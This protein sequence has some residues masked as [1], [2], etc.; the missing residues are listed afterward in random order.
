MT[1]LEV[2][3]P[4]PSTARTTAVQRWLTRLDTRPLLTGAALFALFTGLFAFVQFGTAALADNDGFYHLRLAALM[5]T[6]PS[7]AEA[8]ARP[9]P[10]SRLSGATLGILTILLVALGV[11][12]APLL[13]VIVRAISGSV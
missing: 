4:P 8:A 10:L 6:R 1:Q 2:A 12:P 3:T 5:Y 11:N 7:E 13:E 9:Q